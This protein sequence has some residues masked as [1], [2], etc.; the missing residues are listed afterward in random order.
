MSPTRYNYHFPKINVDEL[1]EQLQG[2]IIVDTNDDYRIITL[3]NGS[4]LWL[5]NTAYTHLSFVPQLHTYHIT[6][7]P[8][9]DVRL[10][11]H[12]QYEYTFRIMADVFH[13][14][15]II[16]NIIVHIDDDY[17]RG[18]SMTIGNIINKPPLQRW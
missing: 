8:I 13:V 3:N 7:R 18:L 14:A 4:S 9:T 10:I 17:Y 2:R 16:I 11:H 5:H 1:K 12:E 6:N 15:D